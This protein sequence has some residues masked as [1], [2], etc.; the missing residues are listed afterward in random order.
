MTQINTILWIVA[1]VFLISCGLFYTFKLHFIQFSFKKM[2]KSLKKESNEKGSISPFKT[3]TLALAARIGVG[4]LA[5]IALGLYKGGVGVIFWIWLSSLI[6]VPNSFVESTLAVK[7]HERDGKFFKGGPAYYIEKGLGF[8]KLAII[9]AIIISLCYL[10]GFLAI[11]SN[12]IAKC[13]FDYASVPTIVTGILVAGISYIIISKGLSRISNFTSFLVPIMGIIYMIV[14]V[15]IIILNFDKV[16]SILETIFTEAFN[17]KAFGWGIIS[18]IIIGVQRGI[19]STEAGT[20]TG[21]VASG[22]S[23][24]KSPSK[25]GYIQMLGV[26]FTSFIVCTSTAMIIL[27]S[28]ID[29]HSFTDPN[30][31]EITLRALESHLGNFGIIILLFLVISFAFSTIISGYYYGESNIKYII[32]KMNNKY[33]KALEVL[34]VIILLYGAIARPSI[35]WESVDLG[36]A[37]LAIINSFSIFMLQGEIKSELGG[38]K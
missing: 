9:Y 1:T 12:T 25:Q 38:N 10:G 11:Q 6:T 36:L 20:G 4:S 30:G 22:V 34:V 15:I 8:K 14:A 21:A 29:I 28:D 2:F 33:I 5:G 7:F 24:T 26:Y 35:L 19:F 32:K 18:S 37:L 27:T 13:L 17:F 31:I 3:L 23:E 16:P